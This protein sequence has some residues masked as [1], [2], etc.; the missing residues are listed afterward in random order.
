MMRKLTSNDTI[1]VVDRSLRDINTILRT[2][3]EP[4][5][6]MQ[7]D[8]ERQR[9]D[10]ALLQK[11]WRKIMHLEYSTEVTVLNHCKDRLPRNV[12]PHC[13]HI[14][15]HADLTTETDKAY[16]YRCFHCGAIL[17]VHKV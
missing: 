16:E 1:P 14:F 7:R 8:S 2:G 9:V 17:N 11:V 5:K 6:P 4:P 12:C 10:R 15:Y 13:E 3:K